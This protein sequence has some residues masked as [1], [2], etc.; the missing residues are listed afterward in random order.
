MGDYLDTSVLDIENHGIILEI[1]EDNLAY[2][3]E[4][5][6]S[7][8]C[9]LVMA[10]WVRK[11]A[12]ERRILFAGCGGN[13]IENGRGRRNLLHRIGILNT[14]TNLIS[15]DNNN[16]LF[17]SGYNAD[18]IETNNTNPDIGKQIIGFNKEVFASKIHMQNKLQLLNKIG[19]RYSRINY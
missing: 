2:T 14:N 1:I 12:C 4:K 15:Y 13:F 10:K 16:K 6:L 9:F 18:S 5:V 19:N 8:F 11:S 17:T 7:W 3:C